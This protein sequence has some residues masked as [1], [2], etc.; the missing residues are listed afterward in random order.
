MNIKTNLN[1]EYV[2]FVGNKKKQNKCLRMFT[3]TTL[4]LWT[5]I[6]VFIFKLYLQ[7]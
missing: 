7:S 6:L 1:E 2:N 5:I 3:N 4:C